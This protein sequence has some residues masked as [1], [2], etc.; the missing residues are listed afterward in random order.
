MFEATKI[1]MYLKVQGKTPTVN[2]GETRKSS[3]VTSR[4]VPPAAYRH[5]LSCL[6]E[7]DPLS[8]PGDTSLLSGRGVAP[9]PV[10]GG[11]PCPTRGTLCPTWRVSPAL[12]WHVLPPGQDQRPDL[13]PEAR[14][15][16]ETRGWGTSWAGPGTGLW[17]G[18]G[19]GLG[20]TPERTRDQRLG[21]DLGPEV[22]YPPGGQTNK[23][24]T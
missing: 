3:C 16:P 19:T 20:C 4:G 18:S 6:G 15:G 9:C 24:K 12:T 13:G 22:E 5:S 21:R 8:F 14:K 2:M 23:V 7:A 11:I 1:C 17:T 10:Q